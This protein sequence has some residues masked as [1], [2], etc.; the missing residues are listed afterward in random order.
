[1][2]PTPVKPPVK[3]LVLLLIVAGAALRV[4]GIS[5]D[6][7]LDE[8][9]SWRIASSMK[10][11]T[12]VLFSPAARY[13]N[14]HPLN[15]LL[16][17]AIGEQ[18]N[19]S[20]WRLPALVCGIGSTV[21]AASFLRRRGVG[22]ML[23][24]AILFSFSYPLIFYSSEARGYSLVVFFAMLAMDALDRYARRPAMLRSVIFVLVCVLGFLSHLTFLHAYLGL[25]V[26]SIVRF[27]RD[28]PSRREML[29]HLARCHALPILFFVALWWTFAR[30]IVIGGSPP[31]PVFAAIID[32]VGRLFASGESHAAAIAACAAV[33]LVMIACLVSL[34]RDRRFDWL[35]LLVVS[36]VF[37]PAIAL[38]YQI[39][40]TGQHQPIAPR[41]FIVP[42][43]MFVVAASIALAEWVRRGGRTRR[44]VRSGLI[45]VFVAANLWQTI[46]FLRV[47]RG[48]YADAVAYIARR[49][50][51]P[52]I[53]VLPDDP[54][55]SGMVLEFYA[56]RVLPPEKRLQISTGDVMW[57]VLANDDHHAPPAQR[58]EQHVF[59]RDFDY[60]GLSGYSW[61]L[62]RGPM[63]APQ[64][65]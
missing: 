1:M 31:K 34:G 62:Y 56:R 47:G 41:Y 45:L 10:S 50:P 55:R 59:D 33:L 11:A 25:L 18:Q 36:V 14:N 19:W 61:Y 53:M 12:D 20:V 44:A 28:A 58:I 48:H 3:L 39:I 46:R 6:F 7:W 8:I 54:L 63:I 9:W 51:S 49:T 2:L 43:A 60:Y 24:G 21:V 5:D 38:A 17:Y 52:V 64:T 37:S 27:S 57:V 15:T 4:V 13:D 16:M 42:Y 23:I 40:S 32:A 26:W 22:E 30:H 65:R 29:T 35:G